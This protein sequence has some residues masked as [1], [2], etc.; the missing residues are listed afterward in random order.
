[1]CHFNSAFDHGPP[2]L[3]QTAPQLVRVVSDS[4]KDGL[5]AISVFPFQADR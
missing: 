2:V 4:T 3:V 5:C 1:M